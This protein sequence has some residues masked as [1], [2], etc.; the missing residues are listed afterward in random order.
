MRLPPGVDSLGNRGL[1]LVFGIGFLVRSIPE[2][3]AFP[4]PI[5]FDTVHYA[6]VMNSFTVWPH[7][8]SFFTSSWLLYALIVPAYWLL[9]TDAFLLLKMVGPVL[10]GMNTAGIYWFARKM[11]AWDIRWALLAGTFFSLQV[12]AL[13][14]SW[15]LLRNELGLGLLLFTLPLVNGV[16]S[17]R[18]FVAFAVFSL[19]T[20]LAHEYAGVTLLVIVVAMLAW[21]F[22]GK[23]ASVH[24]ARLLIG[25]LPA[26]SVFIAGALLRISPIRYGAESNIIE[27]GD[28]VW[29]RVQ[30]TFF[31]VNYLQVNSPVDGYA[32]YSSLAVSV[33]VLFALLYLSYLLLVVK[34]FFRNRV[35]DLWAA[36]LLIGGFGCLFAPFCALEYWHRWLFMLVYPFTFYATNGLK[37]LHERGDAKGPGIHLGVP[38]KAVAAIGLTALLGAVYLATP[39][40]MS[41]SS[42][43]VFSVSPV[44]RYFSVS[45]TVP[46]GDV[47]SV[48]EAM[49]WLDGNMDNASCVLLH[50]AFLSWGKL[51]IRGTRAI[52]YFA[53][54]VYRATECALDHGFHRVFFVWWSPD[55]GWYGLTVPAS[56]SPIQSFGRISVFELV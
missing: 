40:L 8:S 46:Y 43:G 53:N 48:T 49:S 4:F 36:L 9:R 2:I 5:G 7:W 23:S 12:S 54:D 38:R 6:A 17:R 32:S 45:P 22:F 10:F 39:V 14:I 35:L 11:L 13:R 31:L 19:L 29:G 28:I 50:H 30:N 18:G 21:R 34:G 3:L 44:S 25:T 51:Y 55:I 47:I 24:W 27:V 26:L 41:S 16:G 56:F 52:V 1:P 33:L 37:R 20:V 15:D 42:V